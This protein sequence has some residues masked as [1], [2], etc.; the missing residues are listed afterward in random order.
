MNLIFDRKYDNERCTFDSF[1]NDW[2]DEEI[3]KEEFFIHCI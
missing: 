2:V 1:K 3:T